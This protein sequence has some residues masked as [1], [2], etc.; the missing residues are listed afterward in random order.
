ML[1]AWSSNL[2]RLR[3][4]WFC[5]Q[6]CCHVSLYLRCSRD[7]SDIDISGSKTERGV[8]E[9]S[10]LIV[11]KA[12][13]YFDPL[14]LHQVTLVTVIRST[15][16]HNI[17]LPHLPKPCRTLC[18]IPSPVSPYSPCFPKQPSPT[19]GSHRRTAGSPRA[20]TPWSRRRRPK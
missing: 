19:P 11:K 3:S 16:A 13:D 20:C 15:R 10:I 8:N 1:D 7:S 5:F 2:H 17:K 18:W 6:P 9:H 4:D 14:Y 12:K